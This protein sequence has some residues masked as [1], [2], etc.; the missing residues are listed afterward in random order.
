MEIHMSDLSSQIT[1]LEDQLMN[2]RRQKMIED[3][4]AKQLTP[5]QKLAIQLHDALCHHNHTDGCGW[6]YE[7]KNKV[8]EWSRG[9][10]HDGWLSRARKISHFCL[11]KNVPVDTAID[12]FQYMSQ[13]R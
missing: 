11:T 7:I 1:A 4:A 9:S 5:D 8:H 10:T 12:I 6:H 3:E 2:L 13:N